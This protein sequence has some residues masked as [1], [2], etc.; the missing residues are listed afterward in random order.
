M[1]LLAVKNVHHKLINGKEKSQNLISLHFCLDLLFKT[2]NIIM[3]PF[4]LLNGSKAFFYSKS[5]QFLT[6]F[7]QSK[8]V[9]NF[10]QK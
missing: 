6:F 8:L 1:S 4:S 10:F 7:K 9:L 3:A 2:V 5:T